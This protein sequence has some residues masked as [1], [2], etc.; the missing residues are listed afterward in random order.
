MRCLNFLEEKLYLWSSKKIYFGKSFP[1]CYPCF[2][3]RRSFRGKLFKPSSFPSLVT[4]KFWRK[5]EKWQGV[6]FWASQSF[7][8]RCDLVF[9]AQSA[10]VVITWDQSIL[11]RCIPG[12]VHNHIP[13]GEC[14]SRSAREI[15]KAGLQV[16]VT[17]SDVPREAGMDLD[18]DPSDAHGASAAIYRSGKPTQSS[19]PFNPLYQIVFSSHGRQLSPDWLLLFFVWQYVLYQS[20]PTYALHEISLH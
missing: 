18:R 10:E 7:G 16:P 3:L 11:I 14:F 8:S 1:K 2:G 5:Q 12:R 4:G 6:H 13:L 15:F 9:C 19:A 17:S 20:L